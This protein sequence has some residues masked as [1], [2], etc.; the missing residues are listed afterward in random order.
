METT[1][2]RMLHTTVPAGS[3]TCHNFG[4]LLFTMTRTPEDV[5]IKWVATIKLK[6]WY[7]K[8]LMVAYTKTKI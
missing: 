8:H 7:D 6:I 4:P 3:V 5:S 1:E 2:K